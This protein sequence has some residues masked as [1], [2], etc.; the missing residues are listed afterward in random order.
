MTRFL[1]QD[2]VTSLAYGYCDISEFMQDEVERRKLILSK[3]GCDM[4]VN[5]PMCH[6]TSPSESNKKG[7]ARS[8]VRHA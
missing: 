6:G 7:N 1:F 8:D 4:P 2:G 3:V 5:L